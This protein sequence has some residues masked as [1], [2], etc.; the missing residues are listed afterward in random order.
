ME[1]MLLAEAKARR[2]ESEK[3]Q[4]WTRKLMAEVQANRNESEKAQD[5]AK[6]LSAELETALVSPLAFT[7]CVICQF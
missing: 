1:E 5:I 7:E 2:S 6:R 4:Q 3:A